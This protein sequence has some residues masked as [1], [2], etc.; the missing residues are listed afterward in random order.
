MLLSIAP[1]LHIDLTAS[2]F[3]RVAASDASSTGGG[4][5]S[6]FCSPALGQHLWP[7]VYITN[8]HIGQLTDNMDCDAHGMNVVQPCNYF[9][10]S[11]SLS[12]CAVDCLSLSSWSTICSYQWQR[13]EHINKLELHALITCIRWVL[14]YPHAFS[15]SRLL[16]LVDSAVVY[17]CV[18]KGRSNSSELIILLRRL[19]ALVL[20]SGLV[21]LPIWVPSHLNPA[22]APSR[23]TH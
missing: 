22:D 12:Q 6:S 17:Y 16:C 9:C 4:V 3:D 23:S 18:R 20:S 11:R 8:K 21:L 1:L 7:S 15:S 13:D 5:V 19:A 2:F 10:V 14:S